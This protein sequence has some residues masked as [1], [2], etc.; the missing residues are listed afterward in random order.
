VQK[1]MTN[2]F[3]IYFPADQ[4]SSGLLTTEKFNKEVLR[5]N[6]TSLLPTTTAIVPPVEL[7]HL[8]MNKDGTLDNS[9]LFSA[10][11]GEMSSSRLFDDKS[12]ST[13]SEKTGRREFLHNSVFA[14]KNNSKLTAHTGSTV[15]LPCRVDKE[16]KFE[17]VSS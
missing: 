2:L 16:S 5:K 11:N 13:M 7:T 3:S 15:V 14:S 4:R 17:M 12:S 10:H 1:Q 8:F 9:L 6:L